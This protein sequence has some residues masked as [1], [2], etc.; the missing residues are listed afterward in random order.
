MKE[1][2]MITWPSVRRPY[3]RPCMHESRHFRIQAPVRFGSKS[4]GHPD[5]KREKQQQSR[6]VILTKFNLYTET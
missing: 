5:I 2:L 6:D 3:V 4:Y 1:M